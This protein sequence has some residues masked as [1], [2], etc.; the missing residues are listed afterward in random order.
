M[1][2]SHNQHAAATYGYRLA[3]IEMRNQ[4]GTEGVFA[5]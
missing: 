5:P 2:A 1:L 4:T 3:A